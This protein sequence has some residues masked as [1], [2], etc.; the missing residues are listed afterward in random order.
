MRDDTAI[1]ATAGFVH[2]VGIL[3]LEMVDEF[4][5][6]AGADISL[7]LVPGANNDG[8]LLDFQTSLVGATSVRV[9]VGSGLDSGVTPQPLTLG[10][11]AIRLKMDDGLPDFEGI[12]PAFEPSRLKPVSAIAYHSNTAL[13]VQA[14]IDFPGVATTTTLDLGTATLSATL[15]DGQ[16][17]APRIGF[18][19][20]DLIAAMRAQLTNASPLT[21]QWATIDSFA[22]GFETFV[23][24][25]LGDL[26]SGTGL[27]DLTIPG[28]GQTLD[29]I[30]GLKASLRLAQQ[31]LRDAGEDSLDYAAS[32]IHSALTGADN[33]L[34]FAPDELRVAVMAG[35]ETDATEEDRTSSVILDLQGSRVIEGEIDL[36]FDLGAFGVTDPSGLAEKLGLDPSLLSITALDGSTLRYALSVDLKTAVE[37]LADG[38]LRFC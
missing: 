16:L 15:K 23:E 24:T 13:D 18:A 27:I 36:G 31:A 11:A 17:T 38:T 30:T 28:V 20:D 9:T 8:L 37:F 21:A 19:S 10:R 35:T 12:V 2:G 25:M 4:G 33:P 29:E 14:A 26:D 1:K 5:T 32:I 7:D 34:R 22:T 6:R 3:P